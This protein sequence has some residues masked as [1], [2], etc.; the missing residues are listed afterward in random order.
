MKSFLVRI[1]EDINK[2]ANKSYPMQ[3]IKDENKEHLM[4]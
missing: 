4:S 3:S 1:S 2:I